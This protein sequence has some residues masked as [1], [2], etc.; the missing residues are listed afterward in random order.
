[1]GVVDK[2]GIPLLKA[3]CIATNVSTM[4]NLQGVTCD[5][6][7][8][9]GTPRGQALKEAGNYT[10]YMAKLLHTAWRD[11]ARNI[12]RASAQSVHVAAACVLVHVSLRCNNSQVQNK[13][14]GICVTVC[15]TQGEGFGSSGPKPNRSEG[16]GYAGSDLHLGKGLGSAGPRTSMDGQQQ[17]PIP[18]HVPW[19]RPQDHFSLPYQRSGIN[20]PVGNGMTALRTT[21]HALRSLRG[22]PLPGRLE[23]GM[24]ATNANIAAW[25]EFGVPAILLAAVAA[26]SSPYG[27]PDVRVR[28]LFR[29]VV[30][31]LLPARS[32]ESYK[33]V[34]GHVTTFIK[35]VK[36]A[37]CTDSTRQVLQ[38]LLDHVIEIDLFKSIDMFV[39][40]LVQDAEEGRVDPQHPCLTV[41]T[42]DG[43]LDPNVIC[44][45]VVTK[46]PWIYV[47]RYNDWMRLNSYF[48]ENLPNRREGLPCMLLN[49]D[50]WDLLDL[51]WSMA[52]Q[53][54]YCLRSHNQVAGNTQMNVWDLT[55]QRTS[56]RRWLM[57]LT[58]FKGCRLPCTA[59]AGWP[60]A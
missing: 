58:A 59:S 17:R 57:Q 9:H 54:G 47:T 14:Q 27:F 18:P 38:E 43:Y 53:V 24:V 4:L 42:T 8:A 50:C 10:P 29:G 16:F 22:Q 51:V 15:P 28:E 12:R 45:P 1:M 2:D 49:Q 21:C 20:I 60:Q 44:R 23:Q 37:I 41:V 56:R 33:T 5:N 6:T 7:H 46:S 19:S 32:A 25:V 26:P 34:L 11:E 30:E 36:T 40:V 35:V 39:D 48:R 52:K 55:P 31:S 3:W 13:F